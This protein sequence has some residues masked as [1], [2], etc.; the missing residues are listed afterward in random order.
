MDNTSKPQK[1]QDFI[2]I[3]SIMFDYML[4]LIAPFIFALFYYGERVLML[5]AVSV[6]TCV[7]CRRLG[8][9]I[10]KSEESSRDFS[11]IV[12]GTTVAL[13]LPVTAPWWL[14]VSG[15][16]FAVVICVLPF[17]SIRKSPFVPAAAAICFLT[18][19]WNDLMFDFTSSG[20]YSLA[21]MLEQNNSIGKNA[22][23]FFEAFTGSLPSAVGAGSIIAL[24]GVLIF[25]I[26]RRPK[27]SIPVLSFLTAVIIMAILF[28]R[29]ST[30][31]IMSVVMEL[32]SGTLLFN[33]IFFMSYPTVMPER[34]VSRAL[35]G[36][37]GGIVCM[38]IRFFGVFEEPSCFG[39]VIICAISELFDKVPLT[40]NEKKKLAVEKPLDEEPITVVPDDVLNE[41]PDISEEAFE[42]EESRTEEKEESTEDIVTAEKET[43][44]AIIS[45]ENTVEEQETPFITGGDGNE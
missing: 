6:I 3:R 27:S 25:L 36:F 38:L 1:S 35:W 37:F 32:C 20:K 18:I 41:I 40:P 5:V 10:L 23:A 22:V 34:L 29:V 31:R 42:Q 39:I 11:S 14:A 19:C 28:P 33:A 24:I 21:K 44:D 15:A 43:L 17:G 4:M 2:E 7:I 16:F 30:G 8:N 26:I 12:I 9:K 13:L 45:E